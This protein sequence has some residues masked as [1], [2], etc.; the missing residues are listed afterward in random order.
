MTRASRS[1]MPHSPKPRARKARLA[2]CVRPD[3]ISLPMIRTQAVT[4]FGAVSLLDIVFSFWS[5]SA[6]HRPIA[7]RCT[8]AGV[9]GIAAGVTA[10]HLQS[11]EAEAA[12][13]IARLP[14]S[15]YHGSGVLAGYEQQQ[16]ATRVDDGARADGGA[17]RP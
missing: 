3:R 1:R 14:L 4:I 7:R 17:R 9:P 8:I 6:V 13:V 2:S 12:R 16:D 15:D 5:R 10:S 11:G